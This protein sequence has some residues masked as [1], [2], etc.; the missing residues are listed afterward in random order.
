MFSMGSSFGEFRVNGKRTDDL[1]VNSEIESDVFQSMPH[2][3]PRGWAEQGHFLSPTPISQGSEFLNL[4]LVM[5][6]AALLLDLQTSDRYGS[7]ASTHGSKIQ[8][9]CSSIHSRNR[10][11]TPNALASTNH[12]K[13]ISKSE[14]SKDACHGIRM[15]GR[16]VRRSAVTSPFALPCVGS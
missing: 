7:R 13:C 4:K 12:P 14:D 11:A 16:A 3:G 2:T 1:I 5:V 8:S 10:N 15:P 6:R 9:T